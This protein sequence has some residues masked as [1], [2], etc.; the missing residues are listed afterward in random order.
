MTILEIN[1]LTAFASDKM[2]S[3]YIVTNKLEVA[4]HLIGW[5]DAIHVRASSRLIWIGIS[6]RLRQRLTLDEAVAFAWGEKHKA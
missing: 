2:A 1:H 6:P 5:S 4:D 3:L